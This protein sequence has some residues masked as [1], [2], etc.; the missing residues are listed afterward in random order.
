MDNIEQTLLPNERIVYS[1]KVCKH[2]LIPTILF[3]LL[4]APVLVGLVLLSMAWMHN[5][6]TR[7]VLTNKRVIG[8]RGFLTTSTQSL[9]LEKIES[10][11]IS[12][13]VLGRVWKYGSID[14]SGAGSSLSVW[15]IQNPVDF[16]QAWM[17]EAARAAS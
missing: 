6:T 7:L 9:A 11:D 14:V 5:K 2:A 17:L 1:A 4:I 15:D 3:G 10:V 8:R 12:Q 16:R 13:G